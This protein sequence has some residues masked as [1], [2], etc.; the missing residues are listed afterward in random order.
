MEKEEALQHL[1]AAMS[2]LETLKRLLL[3]SGDES[4]V[5]MPPSDGICLFCKEP[6]HA[7]EKAY[8]GVHDRCSAKMRR[9]GISKS[10]AVKKG[11]LGPKTPGGRKPNPLPDHVLKKMMQEDAEIDAMKAKAD[12]V[13]KAHR[14][15]KKPKE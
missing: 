12:E 11:L 7:N 14:A 1:Q 6:I 10:E 13:I 4:V 3:A 8:R 5:Q 15:K 9:E 2:Q